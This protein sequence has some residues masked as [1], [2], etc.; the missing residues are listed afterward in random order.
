MSVLPIVRP[1]E[2]N[3]GA[4][5]SQDTFSGEIIEVAGAEAVVVADY[6]RSSVAP[7]DKIFA[8]RVRLHVVGG[9]PW[10][11]GHERA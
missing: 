8:C 1:Q 4:S 7:Q 3:A 9:A 5:F 10:K 6:P 2:A 11:R